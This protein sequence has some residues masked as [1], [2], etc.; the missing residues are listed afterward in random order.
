MK[1][2]QTKESAT[3]DSNRP[4]GVKSSKACEELAE[5]FASAA[6]NRCPQ[7]CPRSEPAFLAM[8]RSAKSPSPWERPA[9]TSKNINMAVTVSA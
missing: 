5:P 8:G 6:R 2:Y 1:P 7:P 4:H 9:L 3:N